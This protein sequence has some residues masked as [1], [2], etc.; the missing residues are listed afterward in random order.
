M[1]PEWRDSALLAGAA[2][3]W[4]ADL[5]GALV[6]RRSRSAP[7]L[8]AYAIRLDRR[9]LAL[10]DQLLRPVIESATVSGGDAQAEVRSAN[11]EVSAQRWISASQRV[12]ADAGSLSDAG[13]MLPMLVQRFDDS[14][15][16]TLADVAV[17]LPSDLIDELDGEIRAVV[18]SE[19]TP[20]VM[21]PD[22]LANWIG[23]VSVWEDLRAVVVE[24][25]LRAWLLLRGVDPDQ[26][27]QPKRSRGRRGLGA[28]RGPRR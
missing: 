10:V 25:P 15:R 7:P 17:T 21:N 4:D 1:P 19:V 14:Q 23:D 27:A 2:E 11:L 9:V 13:S 24:A 8:T 26:P 3:A 20:D 12:R 18:E 22:D 16:H 6:R 5:T 28:R